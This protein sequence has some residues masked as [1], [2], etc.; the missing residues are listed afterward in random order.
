MV[1]PFPGAGAFYPIAH[2]DRDGE[3]LTGDHNYHLHLPPN[4]PAKLFWSVT[5]YDASNSSGL[6]NGQPFPSL[7]SRDKPVINAD[8]SVDLYF[9]D[10]ALA[11]N[12]KY[13][14][15]TPKGKG[16]F[17]ILRLYG[18]LEPAL[19]RTWKPDDLERVK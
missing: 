11:S 18:P 3:Y 6:E 13:W 5:V 17:V 4:P 2:R 10:Q 16:Y 15:R 9:G 14:L 7:G 19:D 12:E 1:Y 8:G